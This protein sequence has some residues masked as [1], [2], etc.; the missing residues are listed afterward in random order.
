MSPRVADMLSIGLS[1]PQ[2][3]REHI[4]IVLGFASFHALGW[5]RD[6]IDEQVATWFALRDVERWAQHALTASGDVG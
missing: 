1:A 4:D 5:Y 2:T 6:E 3:G